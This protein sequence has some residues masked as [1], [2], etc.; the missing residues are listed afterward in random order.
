MKTLSFAV[1]FIVVTI[2]LASPVLAGERGNSPKES[3]E[4]KSLRKA[5]QTLDRIFLELGNGVEAKLEQILFDPKPLE[6]SV[7]QIQKKGDKDLRPRAAAVLAKIHR[8]VHK[9]PFAALSTVAPHIINRQAAETWG[10]TFSEKRKEALAAWKTECAKQNGEENPEKPPYMEYVPFPLVRAWDVSHNNIYCAVEAGNALLAMKSTK[11]ALEVFNFIGGQHLDTLG[12][13]LAG[14]GTGDTHC[15]DAD[16]DKAISFYN[17]A[18][19]VANKCINYLN[20]DPFGEIRFA[21]GRI[22]KKLKEAK[23]LREISLYGEGWVLYKEAEQLRRKDERFVS[24]Y[25]KY[26]E[27]T[28]RFSKTAYAEAS[29]AYMVKC[30]FA[31]TEKKYAAA[32]AKE[33]KQYEDL[34]RSLKKLATQALRKA[35]KEK[36]VAVKKILKEEEEF[37]KKF[38]AVPVGEPAGDEALKQAEA[39]IT[40]EEFGL[41][42]GEA[43]VDSGTYFLESRIDLKNAIKWL[44]RASGWFEKARE[45]DAKLMDVPDKARIVSATPGSE[46]KR[47]T[48]GNV[49]EEEIAIG[50]VINRRTTPWYFTRL[51]RELRLLRGVTK[52]IK[53]DTKGANQDFAA[54]LELD[55]YIASL[56]AGGAPN[57]YKRLKEDCDR[58]YFWGWPEDLKAFSGD[59]KT[60]V[61]LGGFYF[62][63]NKYGKASHVYNRLFSGEFG[64]LNKEEAAFLHQGLGECCYRNRNLEEAAKHFR[65]IL[66]DYAGTPTVPKAMLSLAGTLVQS[67]EGRGEAE[68]Y[69]KELA[70]KYPKTIFG[71]K[72]LYYSAFIQSYD[73]KSESKKT[74]TTFIKRYPKSVYIYSAKQILAVL[75]K[76]KEEKGQN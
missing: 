5:E 40:K 62:E 3:P 61:Y 67:P 47:D 16:Y 51:I 64:K 12:E 53:G 2:G 70:S 76:T 57:S 18:I 20:D 33:I 60:A 17:H 63:L 42:R 15:Q 46:K 39:F 48:W 50:A 52:F 44:E 19:K 72:A 34:L 9:D 21:K 23:R 35:S 74:F 1:G 38:Q 59:K 41:Y 37:V 4:Q 30:L 10:E 68:K 55:K 13:V 14:E 32:A 22:E 26:A 56:H 66:K 75:A 71:E 31:L 11:K 28:E 58:G 36:K 45:A 6:K 25:L 69:Y 27:I 43:M 65:K 73:R 7:E 29:G 49:V 54:L 8:Y 24:A